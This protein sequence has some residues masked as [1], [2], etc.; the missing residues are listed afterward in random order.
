M[1]DEQLFLLL[2]LALVAIG[3]W[4]VFSALG[5]NNSRLNDRLT[6]EG[7]ARGDEPHLDLQEV[8]HRVGETAGKALQPKSDEEKNE[9][10]KRLTYAGIYSRTGM[11]MFVGARVVALLGGLL[12]GALLGFVIGGDK[13]ALI[14]LLLALCGG[15]GGYLGPTF[16]LDWR[17]RSNRTALDHALPDALDLM[18]VC[19]ESGLAVDASFQRVGRE[20]AMAHPNL[21]REF[22]TAHLETQM[23]VPRNQALRNIYGR[24]GS[25]AIQS[26]AAM[27]IQADRFGTSIAQALR[28]YSESLRIKRQHKAEEKAATAAVKITFPLVLFV[29]PALLIVIGGPAVLRISQL[30]AF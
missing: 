2:M 23:G 13:A 3:V 15:M 30:D 27:L 7:G 10:R 25:E 11:S 4:A 5:R 16:W 29:F 17:V 19:V 22:A 12:G 14:A 28:V 8:L 26:L 18:V 6:G 24:T 1:S 9:L 20:I 21:A